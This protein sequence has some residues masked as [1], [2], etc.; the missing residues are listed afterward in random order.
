MRIHLADIPEE[1]KS[2][3]W[4]NQT[5]ELNPILADLIGS[6]PYQAEF[7]IR[8]LN[9]KDYELQGSIK[10][11]IPEACS[12]CGLDFNLNVDDRF[13][14]ILI[15]RQE[16]TRTGKYARVNHVSESLEE[17]PEVSEYDGNIFEM[18]EYLHERVALA[19]PFNPVAPEDAN[20]DC[21]VCKIPLKGHSFSYDEVMPEDKPENPFQVLKNIKLS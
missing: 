16:E 12:R 19:A 1:G 5:A 7:F 6:T 8:P 11:Q 10:T 15:P 20:G 14:A 18:G 21:S 17:G 3:I 4:N 2:Y 13:R 9:S